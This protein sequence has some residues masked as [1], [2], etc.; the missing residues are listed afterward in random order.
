MAVSVVADIVRI[1]LGFLL[2]YSGF[3]KIPDLK[4]FRIIVLSYGILPKSFAKLFA[5]FLPFVDLVAGAGLFLNLYPPWF[6]LLFL[7]L[8]VVSTIGILILL[9]KKKKMENCGC[10][11]TAVKIPIGKAKVAENTFWIVLGLFLFLVQL[12]VF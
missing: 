12:G 4:G 10:F 8:L 3:A 2:L 6:A 9:A 1:V 5:F 7:V 11:G